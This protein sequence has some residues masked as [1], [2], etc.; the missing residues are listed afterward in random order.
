MSE[1]KRNTSVA[2]V[3]VISTGMALGWISFGRVMVCGGEEMMPLAANDLAL[4][5][6]EGVRFVEEPGVRIAMEHFNLPNEP[7]CQVFVRDGKPFFRLYWT[8]RNYKGQKPPLRWTTHSSISAD[9]LTFE[10]EH[11]P[12]FSLT[13]RTDRDLLHLPD[14][15]YRAYTLIGGG[16][17]WYC[18]D[19]Y[20]GD[21]VRWTHEPGKRITFGGEFDTTA[22][23]GPEAVFLPDG[24]VRVYYIGWSGSR[25]PYVK[26]PGPN[27]RW[28]ILSAVSQ[29]GLHFEKEQGV[30]MDVSPSGDPPHGAIAMAKPQVVKL[31]GGKWRM[32]Y[33]AHTQT[34]IHL[35]SAVS[36]DGLNWE[37]EPGVK[38]VDTEGKPI[39]A[40]Y[41]SLVRCDDCRLRMYY[42]GSGGI[43]SA[44]SP[45]VPPRPHEGGEKG[46]D[47]DR[48]AIP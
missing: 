48:P 11:G 29:D 15:R 44:V 31:K 13:N 38:V 42:D 45:Q 2:R 27:D 16:D 39:H 25:G 6:D 19:S 3:V 8:T 41:P 22:S 4:A 17:P 1:K 20:I 14:S 32:Y 10:Y 5:P 9:G 43:R 18:V 30:R 34:G 7:D 40:K 26:D 47:Q 23:R 12:H 24:R 28:R 37:R 46:S 33:A 36:P 21:G 35:F